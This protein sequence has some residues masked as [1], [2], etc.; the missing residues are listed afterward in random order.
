MCPSLHVNWIRL[1]VNL[2]LPEL[3]VESVAELNEA[4]NKRHVCSHSWL[5]VFYWITTFTHKSRYGPLQL[6]MIKKCSYQVMGLYKGLWPYTWSLFLTDFSIW[7]LGHDSERSINTFNLIVC[8]C[9]SLICFLFPPN[10]HFSHRDDLSPSCS[11]WNV[12]CLNAM[13]WLLL[14]LF[15][16]LFLGGRSYKRGLILDLAT[17]P[18]CHPLLWPK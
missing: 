8:F 3:D 13:D 17:F 14:L 2:D 18:P 9:F 15:F 10:N 12:I 16:P 4:S 11:N 7:L 6:R 1:W 5:K